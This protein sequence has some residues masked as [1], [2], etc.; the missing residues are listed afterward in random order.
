MCSKTI[1]FTENSLLPVLYGEHDKHLKL[2]ELEMSV[3]ITTRGNFLQ[4]SGNKDDVEVT[5]NLLESL[6]EDVKKKQYFGCRRTKRKDKY[7]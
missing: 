7:F 3:S 6:Y 1:S 5:K 4:M 2:V